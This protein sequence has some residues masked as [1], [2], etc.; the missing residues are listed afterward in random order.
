MSFRRLHVGTHTS[1]AIDVGRREGGKQTS[2]SFHTALLAVAGSP[3]L[4]SASAVLLS[5]LLSTLPWQL[6]S[7]CGTR[8]EASGKGRRAR[9]GRVLDFG[10]GG[11]DKA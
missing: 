2:V 9:W 10:A 4:S 5:M 8:C 11:R 6:T 1:N 7:V 3:L